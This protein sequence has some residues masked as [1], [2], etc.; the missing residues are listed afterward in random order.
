MNI[1]H[2]IDNTS[3]YAK[4]DSIISELYPKRLLYSAQTQSKDIYLKCLEKPFNTIVITTN[5]Y[6]VDVPQNIPCIVL[7]ESSSPIYKDNHRLQFNTKIIKPSTKEDFIQ[8]IIEFMKSFNKNIVSFPITRAN[9]Q[10]FTWQFPV[11]TEKYCFEKVIQQPKINFIYVAI[12]FAT[13]IDK[14]ILPNDEIV[15][16]A[17]HIK[18]LKAK[19]PS[20][21]VITT[22]QHIHYNRIIPILG[23]I[24]I[25]DLYISHKLANQTKINSIRLHGLPLYPVNIFDKTRCIGIDSGPRKY[26]FS[27]IGAHM[28]HYLNPIR[29]TILSWPASKD[30]TYYIQ[31]TGIWHFEKDVYQLQVKGKE[32]SNADRDVQKI[33]NMIYNEVLSLSHFS[34]C[35]IGAGPNTIR[36]WESI[37]L[38][39]IPVIIADEFNIRDFIPKR[40]GKFYIELKYNAKELMSSVHLEKYLREYSQEDI[41]SMRQNCLEVGK[42]LETNFIDLSSFET[43]C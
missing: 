32:I 8:D 6:S 15:S 29:K 19:E 33:Q 37:C 12:P 21:K 28:N 43:A 16:I 7:D 30:D 20:L 14:N 3:E 26:L 5:E 9:M 38:G 2:Y 35:P 24:G 36:L 13:L 10:Q 41:N 42:Y 11:I 18:A 23:L 25:T 27:F 40:F 1:I 39:S 22:C 34:L 4:F 17:L 31:D